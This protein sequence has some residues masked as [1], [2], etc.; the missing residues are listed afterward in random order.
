MRVSA[1][2]AARSDRKDCKRSVR[3]VR[4][5]VPT[6]TVIVWGTPGDGGAGAADALHVPLLCEAQ[7]T[8]REVLFPNLRSTP[9]KIQSGSSNQNREPSTTA[10]SMPIRP[11][12]A[13]TMRRQVA[14]PMPAGG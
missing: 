6:G 5:S 2:S 3:R 10:G 14:R 8:R 12:W 4:L 11:P 7:T 9:R 1:M 13:P